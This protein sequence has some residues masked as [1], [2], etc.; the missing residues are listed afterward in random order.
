[1]RAHLS[2]KELNKPCKVVLIFTTVSF[3]ILTNNTVALL[4]PVV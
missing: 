4:T 3:Q 2:S 1:M